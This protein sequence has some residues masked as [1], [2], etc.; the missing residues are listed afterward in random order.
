MKLWKTLSK[1]P[2]ISGNKFLRVEKHKVEA[3]D[4]TIIDDWQI[5]ITPDFVNIVAVTK[6]EKF[7]I[8]KQNKYAV[9]GE[10]LAPVGGYIEPGEDPLNA[11]KREL[12][13]E[14]GYASDEWIDLGSYIIDSNRGCGKSFLFLAKN[15][16][17]VSEP[18]EI[19]IELPE[20]H[21]FHKSEIET[22]LKN[23]QFKVLPWVTN[24][25][26]ALKQLK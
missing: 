24:I 14:T 8:L 9:D 4:G 13:E 22:A 5:V 2:F 3:P 21:F 11:A 20:I 19:D 6:D 16:Y 26:F 1:E 25:L 15:I 12:Q 7:L 23:N 10:S 18:T 17:K